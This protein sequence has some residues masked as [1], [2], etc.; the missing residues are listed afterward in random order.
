MALQ[1]HDPFARS[2]AATDGR[3]ARSAAPLRGLAPVSGLPGEAQ[4]LTRR[5]FYRADAVEVGQALVTR[6]QGLQ[7]VVAVEHVTVRS[8]M[9][10]FSR[11]VLSDPGFYDA[12]R[13]PAHQLVNLRDWRATALHGKSEAQAPCA[14]LIDDAY[15]TDDGIEE[16]RLTRLIFPTAATL[17]VGGMEVL[18][19]HGF[20]DQLRPVF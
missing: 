19:A 4:V 18:S 8:R 7:P 20:D 2:F 12:L 16:L 5:G 13:L 17:Y 15:V 10:R 11:E 14:S 6:E 9:V 3:P 1:Q